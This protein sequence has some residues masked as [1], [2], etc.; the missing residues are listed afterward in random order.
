MKTKQAKDFVEEL[1]NSVTLGDLVNSATPLRFIVGAA[2]VVGME[3]APGYKIEAVTSYKLALLLKKLEP[4][5]EAHDTA[6][7][8]LLNEYGEAVK[9]DKGNPTINYTFPDPE[10]A[11]LF[12]QKYEE[13]LKQVVEMDIPEIHIAE[14]KGLV[15]EPK[16]LYNLAWLIKQ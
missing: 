11:E 7:M 5:W 12:K 4:H 3:T 6:R 1:S 13:L 14:F 2:D 8:S 10:K 16:H 9:D 15:I